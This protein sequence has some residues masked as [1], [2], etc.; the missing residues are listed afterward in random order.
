MSQDDFLAWC[1][2]RGIDCSSIEL[3]TDSQSG[4]RAVHSAAHKSKVSPGSEVLKVPF[5]A[6]VSTPG[7]RCGFTQ[8]PLDEGIVDASKGTYAPSERL[9]ATLA[10]MA[11]SRGE[12]WRAYS[13]ALPREV[14][15]PT[16]T[17]SHEEIA[18]C[19]ISRG[20]G[21]VAKTKAKDRAVM[22]GL[23]EKYGAST[24]WVEKFPWALRCVRSRAVDL[25]R[26]ESF[27]APMLDMC[28]HSHG[29][30]NVRWEAAKS[31]DA[32]VLI[33]LTKIEPGEELK[34]RYACE[35]AESF[36]TNMGFVGGMNPFDRVEL[37]GSLRE[38]SIWFTETFRSES[39]EIVMDKAS[40]I[41]V[42]DELD[43]QQRARERASVVGLSGGASVD[44]FGMELKLREMQHTLMGPSVG[45]KMDYDEALWLMFR[46]FIQTL[47][48]N[49]DADRVVARAI[50]KR[51]EELLLSFKT[52]IEEDEALFSA[53]ETP[54]RL[55][56]AV[57]YRLFKKCLLVK[58]LRVDANLTAT[59]ES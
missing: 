20:I 42:A 45:W 19:Q 26:G 32:V 10:Y 9:A 28:N 31:G 23:I 21:N 57:E 4:A 47:M 22:T 48:P 46:L 27:L 2:S 56:T 30:A 43:A 49:E 54:A 38:A 36:L 7:L 58:H 52:T 8:C 50:K 35:P 29:E 41:G 12:G 34:V 24:E 13:D 40:A 15:G 33:A 18:E 1:T 11:S 25:E 17:W 51:C 6:C 53:L 37:W 44:D 59:R 3:V 39:G 55:R 14:D 5:A 16:Y